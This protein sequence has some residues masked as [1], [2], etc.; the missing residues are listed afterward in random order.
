M[1]AQEI[2]SER[3]HHDI[4]TSELAELTAVLMEASKH[5]NKTVLEQNLV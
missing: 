2:D 5:M 3:K 4:L 1:H